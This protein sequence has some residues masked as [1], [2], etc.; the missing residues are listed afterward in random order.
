MTIPAQPE[1]RF[2]W[3]FDLPAEPFWQ[4]VGWKPARM[5]FACF[6]QADIDSMDLMSKPAPSQSDKFELLLQQYETASKALDPLDSNYQR[7]YNLA[8]GRATLL[9]LLGRAEEGDAILKEMLEKPDPSGKPQIATMHNIASR[10]AERGDYAEAEKMV[11]E[12]LPMEEIE[13][14]LGPHSPQALSL[15]R[16]LTEARY[17]LGKSELAKESFQRLVKLTEEAKDTKFRKYEADEKELN[18]EL[19]K[20]LGIE[21][22][23]Q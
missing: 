2:S 11:L 8:M 17:R 6:S 9:P 18:D 16:L 20:K 13:P 3:D 10:V 22:W 5:F 1:E 23:T 21:A 4:A 19:I 12:L 14:K 7:S 15:L